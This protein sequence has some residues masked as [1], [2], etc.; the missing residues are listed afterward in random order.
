MLKKSFMEA[1]KGASFDY[2]S[3]SLIPDQPSPFV[4]YVFKYRSLRTCHLLKDKRATLTT[5]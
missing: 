1:V 5:F 4:I 2:Y 3:S